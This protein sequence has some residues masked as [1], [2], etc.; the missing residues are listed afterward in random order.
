VTIAELLATIVAH[1]DAAGIDHMLAGSMASSFH[2]EPR[3]TQD[4]DLVIDPDTQSL[5]RFV[6]GL[7][8]R[9][10]YVSDAQVALRHRSQFNVI[11]TKTGWKVDLIIR[12]DR[13]FSREEFAR[14]QV[15][16]LFGVTTHLATA[17]D[18]ILA[19]LEWAQAGGS[20]RQVADVVAMLAI[21]GDTLDDTYLARWATELG[22]SGLLSRARLL[23]RD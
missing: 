10:F 20:E 2:G 7:D 16:D 23:A 11:D 4:I 22:V 6:E 21:G 17:E 8:R 9:R 18:T 19:K 14:R 13:P 3:S 12:K 5:A 1:L 15:V